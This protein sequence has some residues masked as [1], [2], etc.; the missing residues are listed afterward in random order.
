MIEYEVNKG[1]TACFILSL[2]FLGLALLGETYNF[3]T[4]KHSKPSTVVKV[5][6]RTGEALSFEEGADMIERNISVE[7]MI[8]ALEMSVEWWNEEGKYRVEFGAPAWVFYANECL[9]KSKST[10][11]GGTIKK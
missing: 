1:A 4:K 5:L 8:K 3:K 11:T 10:G 7:K 2:L 6:Q 9:E